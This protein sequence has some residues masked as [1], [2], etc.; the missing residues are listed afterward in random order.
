MEGERPHHTH[1]GAEPIALAVTNPRHAPE[2]LLGSAIVTLIA[3][4][5]CR[6]CGCCWAC[7][8]VG[9]APKAG[10]STV[11][12]VHTMS[13]TLEKPVTQTI[14]VQLKTITRMGE[15]R[16]SDPRYVQPVSAR[17]HLMNAG[18]H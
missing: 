18:S 4:L 6:A 15:V 13:N 12:G 16:P 17:S 1:D 8:R 10:R 5:Y 11:Q 2:A 7:A 14:P 3:A 9:A